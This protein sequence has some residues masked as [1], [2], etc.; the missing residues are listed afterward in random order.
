MAHYFAIH[1]INSYLSVNVT[2]NAEKCKWA[3]FY[4]L[5]IKVDDLQKYY[6]SMLEL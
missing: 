4:S 6:V 2:H 3:Y 1:T 5:S